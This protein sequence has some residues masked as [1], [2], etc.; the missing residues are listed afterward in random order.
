M[1]GQI[2]LCIMR[3]DQT[4]SL[5]LYI[6]YIYE[7]YIHMYILYTYELCIYELF[8][9]MNSCLQTVCVYINPRN[10]RYDGA[11]VPILSSAKESKLL[12]F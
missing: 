4:M 11:D 2:Y 8:V 9:Y 5:I 1:Y 3:T 6:D 7:L 10:F 12:F